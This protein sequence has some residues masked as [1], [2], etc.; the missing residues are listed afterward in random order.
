MKIHNSVS[1][2]TS[3]KS[4]KTMLPGQMVIV[5]DQK[6]VHSDFHNCKESQFSDQ[7]LMNQNYKQYTTT[8]TT[9]WSP[10]S[11]IWRGYN[12]CRT[13]YLIEVERLFIEN[14]KQYINYKY[15]LF[16]SIFRQVKNW[17]PN[18]LRKKIVPDTVRRLVIGPVDV[19]ELNFIRNLCM[20][21][22]LSGLISP[23]QEFK[24]E[25]HRNFF[26]IISNL[27]RQMNGFYSC[28]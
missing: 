3:P 14:Y 6:W 12:V 9:Q 18:I 20:A 15:S 16:T 21:Q 28:P 19:V 17:D 1:C 23:I 2:Q 22:N 5:E 4:N 10:T 7:I 24:I 11:G 26:S 25:W 13:F 27:Q 8:T